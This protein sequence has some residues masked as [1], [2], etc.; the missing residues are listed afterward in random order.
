MRRLSERRGAALLR[1]VS[2]SLSSGVPHS[3]SERVP[4]VRD[5]LSLNAMVAQLNDDQNAV[6][7]MNKFEAIVAA[8]KTLTL[9]L[10]VLL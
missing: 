9:K 5:R 1:Q 8:L 6:G 4:Q 2:Q 3:H 10:I 7:H